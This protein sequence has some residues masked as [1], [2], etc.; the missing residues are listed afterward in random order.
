MIILIVTIFLWNPDFTEA[1]YKVGNDKIKCLNCPKEENENNEMDS[2]EEN[3]SVVTKTV[4][5]N[6]KVIKIN[7]IEAKKES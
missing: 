3:D 5:T 6:G 4:S 2:K 7:K 1:V